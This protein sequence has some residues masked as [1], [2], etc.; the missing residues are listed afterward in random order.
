MKEYTK[1]MLGVYNLA[2]EERFA[3]VCD[4][5]W[6]QTDDPALNDNW[7]TPE[8]GVLGQGCEYVNAWIK[9]PVS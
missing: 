7:S 9:T 5:E 3:T 2:A 4:G 6:H 1:P 8:E